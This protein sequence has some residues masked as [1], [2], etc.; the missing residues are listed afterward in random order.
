MPCVLSR[1]RIVSLHAR[2]LAVGRVV[3]L[4]CLKLPLDDRAP[5]G[6]AI[7]H[8]PQPLSVKYM[9]VGP[10]LKRQCSQVFAEIASGFGHDARRQHVHAEGGGGVL[11]PA[12]V[13][14]LAVN[15]L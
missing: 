15:I 5:L 10:E 6:Q 14:R 8:V 2:A 7:L 4:A 3:L 9:M 1:G 11:V 12:R 13:R